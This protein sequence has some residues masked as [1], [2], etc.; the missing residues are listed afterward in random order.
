MADYLGLKLK[1]V[2]RKRLATLRRVSSR[3]PVLAKLRAGKLPADLLSAIRHQM[4]SQPMF[5]AEPGLELIS[6]QGKYDPFRQ[7][8]YEAWTKV[9]GGGSAV[10]RSAAQQFSNSAVQESDVAVQDYDGRAEVMLDVLEET[11]ARVHLVPM[12]EWHDNCGRGVSHV[13]GYLPLLARLNLIQVQ[14][15]KTAPPLDG[16]QEVAAAA[17]LSPK[18]KRP[19][20]APSCKAS[21]AIRSKRQRLSSRANGCAAAAGPSGKRPQP[22]SGASGGPA[23]RGG[24]SKAVRT[25]RLARGFKIFKLGVS[26][27]LYHW[28]PRGRAAALSKLALMAA[29]GDVLRRGL[30]PPPRTCTEWVDALAMVLPVSCRN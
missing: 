28:L 8:L 30:A 12:Q 29:G 15:Q 18:R 4:S 9:T 22:S 14:H 16:G 11:V 13:L 27:A 20:A 21:A 2:V 23:K 1:D 17:R 6:L 19:S 7:A 24:A 25:P 5:A 10:R 26:G 3:L